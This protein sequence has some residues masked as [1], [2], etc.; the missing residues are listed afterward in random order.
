M[1]RSRFWKCQSCGALLQK[2]AHQLDMEQAVESGQL[3]GM[4]TCA[5]CGHSYSAP[6]VYGGRFDVS[7][8]D[9]RCL[10]CG[11]QLRGPAEALD[12]R[13]CPAC[14]RGAI[15]AAPA[16]QAG[17]PLG[18]PGRSAGVWIVLGFVAFA[19]L[20]GYLVYRAI[21][22]QQERSEWEHRVP[23]T[24]IANT[25]EITIENRPGGEA[26]DIFVARADD[27]LDDRSEQI[28]ELV[29]NLVE[30][31]H[32]FKEEQPGDAWPG[33]IRIRADGDVPFRLIHKLIRSAEASGY[34]KIHL[35]VGDVDP[36]AGQVVFENAKTADWRSV[37]LQAAISIQGYVLSCGAEKMTRCTV[38]GGDI[39]KKDNRYDLER[40]GERLREIRE[41]ARLDELRI[42]VEDKAPFRALVGTLRTCQQTGFTPVSLLGIGDIVGD[43]SESGS[44]P[45]CARLCGIEPGAEDVK[46]EGESSTTGLG[47]LG[48]RG[49]GIGGLGYGKYDFRRRGKQDI[50]ILT[51]RPVVMGSLSME[52]IRR[53]IHS[54]HNQIKYC[55]AK[56]LSSNPHLSGKVAVKIV[57]SPKGFVQSAK[58]SSSSL[59][60]AT[61]ER[62]ITGKIRTWKFPEP[63]GGGIVIV[64]YPF[65]LKSG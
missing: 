55:Y 45:V 61:V 8:V 58:V 48:T 6:D 22:H 15:G 23:P 30:R 65:I 44:R 59:D 35:E 36:A 56:E 7:E 11:A 10:L 13:P 9:R 31:R 53:V 26:K 54:H 64:D 2:A 3:A 17:S 37:Q 40:L 60:N 42:L 5:E 16:S 27:V 38:I 50:R 49:R 18:T 1:R 41:H 25:K 62:C 14:N 43:L 47:Q 57:I 21:A 52:I 12:G 33:E 32:C 39:L 20:A 51:G 29:H 46:P 63:K 19:L 24:V 4:V 34:P 28:G